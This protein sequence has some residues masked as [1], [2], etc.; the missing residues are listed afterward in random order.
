MNKKITVASI[1]TFLFSLPLSTFAEAMFFPQLPPLT[2]NITL[3]QLTLN[4]IAVLL[5]VMWV[6]A[7]AFTVIMFILAGFKFFTAQGDPTKVSEATRA[8]IYG[9]AGV[10]VIIL[11][12]SVLAI[13]RTTLGV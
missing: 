11:S 10:A 1:S 8:V 9:V 12:F 13:V 3:Y 7:I 2:G 6:I 5:N 4:V